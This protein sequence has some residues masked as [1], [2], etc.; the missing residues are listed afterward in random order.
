MHLV[1]CSLETVIDTQA[2]TITTMNFPF[3]NDGV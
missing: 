1:L 2:L 3:K